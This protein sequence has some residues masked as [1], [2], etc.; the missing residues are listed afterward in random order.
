MEDWLILFGKKL[1][2]LTSKN[3][4]MTTKKGRREY[5]NMTTKKGRREY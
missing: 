1:V 2:N 4:N 3:K 5:K